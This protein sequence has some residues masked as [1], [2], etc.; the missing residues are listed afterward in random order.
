MRVCDRSALLFKQ[1][2]PAEAAAQTLDWLRSDTVRAR[3]RPARPAS[4][5]DARGS[6]G[7]RR[8]RAR[9]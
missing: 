1:K 6:L 2:Q 8:D 4:A 9:G 7:E 5:G 3:E